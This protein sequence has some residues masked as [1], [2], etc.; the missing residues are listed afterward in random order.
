MSGH[1]L[2]VV[3]RANRLGDLIR[4]A[5]QPL[6]RHLDDEVRLARALS[7]VPTVADATPDLVAFGRSG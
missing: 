5:G 6:L 1:A 7:G 4:G 3:D 2:D